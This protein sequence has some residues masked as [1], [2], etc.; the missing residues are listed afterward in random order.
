MIEKFFS[1]KELIERLIKR[2]KESS[3]IKNKVA[4]FII[5]EKQ[6]KNY[7]I[8]SEAV[9]GAPVFLDDAEM[10]YQTTLHAEQ[11]A[12]LKAANQAYLP[13]CAII[14]TLAPC[15]ECAAIILESGIKKCYYLFPYA[16]SWGEEYLR[17]NGVMA[18]YFQHDLKINYKLK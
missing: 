11:R 16:H 7:Q 5:Q 17:K 2:A 1:Q 6:Y 9:N 10:L 18:E 15:P 3:C 4:S 8:V 14:T 13:Q 12:I